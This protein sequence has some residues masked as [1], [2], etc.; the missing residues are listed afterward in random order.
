VLKL[1]NLHDYTWQPHRNGHFELLIDGWQRS[2]T[3]PSESNA[4][5]RIA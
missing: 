2:T 5:P 4:R 1:V 3:K